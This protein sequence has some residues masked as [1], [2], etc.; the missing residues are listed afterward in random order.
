M[1][2]I[3]VYDQIA[4]LRVVPVVAIE[5]VEAALPLADALIAGGL[6]IA[7]ITFRTQAAAAVIRRL[8][9]ERPQLLVGAG[10]VTH[11]DQVLAAKECG[12]AFAVAPGVNLKVMR[13]ARD[14]GLPFAPGVM[15][16]TDVETALDAGVHVLK[17]FPAAAAGG[18][19]ML[20]SLAAPYAHLGVRFIPTGGISLDNVQEY[21]REKSVLAVGGT[22]LA[23]K[24]DI[25]AGRWQNIAENCRKLC[26]LL[27]QPQGAT[28]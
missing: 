21:L 8:R 25:A 9:C 12:A 10:T 2:G 27:Q 11:P 19:K 22:W 16:P 17:F 15:T 7:E 26:E 18:V 24:D 20:A 23:T 14:A 28:P 3:N 13:A 1:A 6:P 4:R 5:S